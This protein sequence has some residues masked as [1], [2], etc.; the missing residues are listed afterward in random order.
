MIV[1]ASTRFSRMTFCDLSIFLAFFKCLN[2]FYFQ[3]IAPQQATK[4]SSTTNSDLKVWFWLIR[5][6]SN[7]TACRPLQPP[8]AGSLSSLTTNTSPSTSATDTEVT[9]LVEPT[10]KR[11]IGTA[12][13]L[14]PYKVRRDDATASL[15]HW[16]VSESDRKSKYVGERE[17]WW[18]Y[19][20]IAEICSL[21]ASRRCPPLANNRTRRRSLVQR[22]KPRP[23]RSFTRVL[24]CITPNVI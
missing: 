16:V 3:T 10:H 4:V 23:N 20:S 11:V 22:R 2:S 1:A 17:I 15:G 9:A 24:P 12:S 19:W 18:I 5:I 13:S 21:P 6:E 14:R 7:H 8:A